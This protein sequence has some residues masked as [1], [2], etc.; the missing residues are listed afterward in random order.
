MK[1]GRDTARQ[2]D[3]GDGPGGDVGGVEYQQL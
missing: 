3:R 1:A 2:V